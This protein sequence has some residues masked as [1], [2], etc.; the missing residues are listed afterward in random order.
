MITV[1]ALIKG[2]FNYL[3]IGYMQT[4]ESVFNVNVASGIYKY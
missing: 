2:K 1:I 3:I 4:R